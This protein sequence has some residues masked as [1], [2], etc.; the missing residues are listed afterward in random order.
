MEPYNKLIEKI[1]QDLHEG[2][3]KPSD[4]NVDMVRQIYKDLS[5]GTKTV[6]GDQWVKFDMK[7]PNSLV[8]KFKKNLWQFS[9]AKTLGEL[10]EMNNQLLDKGRIRQFPEFLKE[11]K[12]TNIKF[13]QNYLQAEHQTGIKGAQAAEQWKG[14]LKNADLFP[15]LEYRT[16]GDDRVRPEHQLLNGVIK[17]IGDVFWRVYYTPNGWRCRCYIVQTAAK[18]TPGKIDD[19]SVMP[20]FRGNVALDEE[21]FTKKGGFFK[22]LNMDHKAKVN[23]EYMKL[24]APYD[25]AYKS[26]KG[27]KVY[28][29]I[30]ADETDKIANIE[31]AMVIV[32]KLERNVFVRPHIDVQN[33]K[34]PE[35]LIDGELAD[36]KEQRGKNISSNLSSAK[37]QGCKKVVFDIT[38]DYPYTLETF[39]NQLKGHVL[40]HYKDSFDEIIIV[41]GKTAITI[42][43]K[44]LLK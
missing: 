12:K 32:E 2:K 25:E 30:F 16:I 43:V 19:P 9:S 35:Y 4:L 26:K 7:E 39:K 15:N 31:T 24:N 42:K 1:A 41:T 37:K 14:F 6:Y 17:P 10:Q 38:K 44:D 23:A 34:N 36:R 40:A 5:S 13:N 20:E 33:H 21:I 28:S 8:Q 27:N 11:V 29:N 3:M 18:A 22:L